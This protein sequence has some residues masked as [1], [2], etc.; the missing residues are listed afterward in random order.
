MRMSGR[1]G[2]GTR[3]AFAPVGGR[4]LQA[5]GAPTIADAGATMTITPNDR[6]GIPQG[7][8]LL[9]RAGV[10]VGPVVTGY[11]FVEADEG[12]SLT[13]RATNSVG[14][15]AASNAIVP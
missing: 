5:P 9:Y 2:W 14:T 1:R 10:L 7:T 11:A 3:Q 4:T 8:F 6:A 15:S 13:V 12:V